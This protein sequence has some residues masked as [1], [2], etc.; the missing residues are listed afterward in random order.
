[1]LSS[2]IDSIPYHH[3]SL[4]CGCTHRNLNKSRQFH[5]DKSRI[6]NQVGPESIVSSVY[7]S[8]CFSFRYWLLAEEGLK[9]REHVQ[10]LL[11]VPCSCFAPTLALRKQ[12]YNWSSVYWLLQ[13]P[14][15]TQEKE[16]VIIYLVFTPY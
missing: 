2:Q 4:C 1:M 7:N 12:W 11:C 13:T 10:P 16:L 15:V 9:E 14:T 8:S 5:A 3:I 6:V